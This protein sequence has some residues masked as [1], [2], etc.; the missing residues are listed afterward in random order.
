MNLKE[1]PSLRWIGDSAFAS[2]ISLQSITFANLPQLRGFG[3]NAFA[4]CTCL[5][6]VDL[7]EL[8]SLRDIAATTFDNCESLQ[9][10]NFSGVPLLDDLVGVNLAAVVGRVAS[11]VHPMKEG[12]ELP[13]PSK[14]GTG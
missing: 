4:Q 3:K 13:A 8:P 10:I 6:I 7:E 12:A 5:T 14:P 1:L 11:L 9:S 2:C